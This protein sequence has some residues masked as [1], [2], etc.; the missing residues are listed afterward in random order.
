MHRMRLLGTCTYITLFYIYLYTHRVYSVRNKQT[1][2][3]PLQ[4]REKRG[5]GVLKGE[6]MGGGKHADAL[7]PPAAPRASV[8]AGS[9]KTAIMTR[10]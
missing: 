4:N 3:R 10:L 5:G 2:K 9:L 6:G 8:R 1:N 7:V